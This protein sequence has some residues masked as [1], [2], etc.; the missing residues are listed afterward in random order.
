MVIEENVPAS[1]EPNPRFAHGLRQTWELELLISGAVAFA[2]LQIPG[3][4]DRAYERLDPHLS[5]NL[6]MAL[7]AGYYYVKLA[8]YA[9]IT[10]FILHLALRAYWVGLIGLEAVYPRGVRWEEIKYGPITRA[11]YQEKLRPLP[12]MIDK[13]D[14]LC[15]MIFSFAF[16]IV[17]MFLFS[18][19]WGG[20]LALVA[21]AVSRLVFGGERFGDVFRILALLFVMIPLGLSLLDRV[22]GPKLDPA[23]R[24]A[25]GIRAGLAVS[26]RAYFLPLYG[27]TLLVLVSNIR[28]KTIY[29]LLALALGGL[30]SFFFL[31]DLLLRREAIVLGSE[32]YLPAEPGE[33]GVDPAHY[34]DQRPPGLVARFVP[35]IQSDVITDP[36]VRLFIPYSPR[37]HNAAVAKRCPGVK[38]LS[39]EG[40]RFDL[41][42]SGKEAEGAPEAVLRCLAGLHR[43]TLDG[44]PLPDL[45][46]LFYNHP[47]TGLRGIVT[48]IPATS[49]AP[50]SHLL[51]V[52]AV[53]REEPGDDPPPHR[54]R[55]WR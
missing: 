44:R 24:L 25:R 3:G 37:R 14:D 50:G 35:S 34:E 31:N 53:P 54:I 12:A 4:I 18:L 10:S 6:A 52:A 19:L 46:F 2:L 7:F 1:P 11:Y 43:V 15:S 49:L 33:H 38:P 30:V 5:G 20:L 41:R 16:L 8:L 39:E 40:M 55:F 29:P 28:K 32:I 51:Q 21:F 17:L 23:G 13:V 22:L 48:Y 42:R 36:Y 27:P 26:F 9:L 45:G 47:E